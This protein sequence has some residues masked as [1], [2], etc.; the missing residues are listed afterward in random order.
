MKATD[1]VLQNL[2][3]AGCGEGLLSAFSALAE[4]DDVEAQVQLLNEYRKR[5]VA[6]IHSAHDELRRLEKKLRCLDYLLYC[7]REN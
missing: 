3:D 1:G 5:L 6:S 7:M 2:R 4:T